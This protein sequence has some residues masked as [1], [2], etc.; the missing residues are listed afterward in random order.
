MIIYLAIAVVG[1]IFMVMT[2]RYW[3]ESNTRDMGTMSRQW[4][5][6]YNQSH[7]KIRRSSLTPFSPGLGVSHGRD[8]PTSFA[9]SALARLA[10]LSLSG[11]EASQHI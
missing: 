7:P 1:T 5:A 4:L 10:R 2:G 11:T 6:E 3:V 8:R 9:R